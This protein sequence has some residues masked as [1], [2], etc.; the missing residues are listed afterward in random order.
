MPG[1]R[2]T[3]GYDDPSTLLPGESLRMWAEGFDPPAALDC[4]VDAERFATVAAEEGRAARLTALAPGTVEVMVR[5]GAGPPIAR[6]FHVVHPAH[7][8]EIRIEIAKEGDPPDGFRLRAV[9]PCLC[10]SVSLCESW[11]FHPSRR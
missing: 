5:S 8:D 11:Q 4:S 1:A 10:V 9:P 6:T 7:V 2:I 3:T